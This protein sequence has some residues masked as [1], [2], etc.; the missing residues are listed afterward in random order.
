MAKFIQY[1]A[2]QRGW[3]SLAIVEVGTAFG[4]NANHILSSIPCARVFVVDPFMVDYDTQD[5]T[6]K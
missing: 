1:T 2:K 5:I 6:S 3:G 4:G